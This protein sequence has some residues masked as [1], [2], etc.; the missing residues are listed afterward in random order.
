MKRIGTLVMLLALSCL[1]GG[2]GCGDSGTGSATCSGTPVCEDAPCAGSATATYQICTVASTGCAEIIYKG[3][4]GTTKD[5]CTCGV[6]C[7]TTAY[8]TCTQ[9]GPTKACM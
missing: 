9:A 1:V 7:D 4:D 6:G 8:S 2:S 5:T 3:A